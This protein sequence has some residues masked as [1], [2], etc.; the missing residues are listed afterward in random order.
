MSWQLTGAGWG[1]QSHHAAWSPLRAC[2]VSGGGLQGCSLP[3]LGPLL[4]EPPQTCSPTFLQNSRFKD[5]AALTPPAP[6]LR[7]AALIHKNHL[8]SSGLRGCVS[9]GKERAFLWPGGWGGFSP[10]CPPPRPAPPRHTPTHSPLGSPGRALQPQMG[11]PRLSPRSWGTSSSGSGVGAEAGPAPSLPPEIRQEGAPPPGPAE[12][13]LP[14]R[15]VGGRT[16]R[17]SRGPPGKGSREGG[18]Y[19][20]LFTRTRP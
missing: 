8:F 15:A 3:A 14:P 4:P 6:G 5:P 16:S 9:L 10:L 1:P 2:G 20:L 19:R 17:G 7:T 12:P 11:G 18:I 13:R